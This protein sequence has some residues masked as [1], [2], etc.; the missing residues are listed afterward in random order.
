MSNPRFRTFLNI[1]IHAVFEQIRGGRILCKSKA[2]W[3]LHLALLWRNQIGG[4]Q[5]VLRQW[6]QVGGGD[7]AESALRTA[8]RT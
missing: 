3:Q 4:L 5:M 1:A 8:L 7:A 6:G 2:I